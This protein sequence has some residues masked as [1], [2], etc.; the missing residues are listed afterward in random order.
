MKHMKIR[1]HKI[2]LILICSAIIIGVIISLIYFTSQ[3]AGDLVIVKLDNRI[4]RTYSL[5]VDMTEIIE[6]DGQ[7]YNTITISDGVVYVSDA[8]CPDKLCMNMG[9]ISSIGQ[10]IV[11]LPHKLVVTVE[12][13]K[14]S[15]IDAISK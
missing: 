15:E 2:D 4:I 11:C 1:E 13:D 9:Q 8:N 12:G 7:A 14:D 10:S 3:R 5:N 6:V